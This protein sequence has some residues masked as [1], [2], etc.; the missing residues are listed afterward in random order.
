MLSIRRSLLSLTMV[1]GVLTPSIARAQQM[2][3][4]AQVAP[5]P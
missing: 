4:M 1:A 3:Q 2:P 5:Q